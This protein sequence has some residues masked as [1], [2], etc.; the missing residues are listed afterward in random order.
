MK[1]KKSNIDETP[2][3]NSVENQKLDIDETQKHQLW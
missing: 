1:H 3:L 2:T